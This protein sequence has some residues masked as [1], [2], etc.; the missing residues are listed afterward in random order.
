MNSEV[1]VTAILLDQI[2]QYEPFSHLLRQLKPEHFGEPKYANIWKAAAKL[3]DP[4]QRGLIDLINLL[5]D[6]EGSILMGELVALADGA[7]PVP[8]F[9]VEADKVRQACVLRQL[10][11]IAQ[12]LSKA[13]EQGN[14]N[15]I[16][17][18]ITRL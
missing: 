16:P 2:K 15:D 14:P 9:V 5:E 8:Q 17:Q 13:H 18:I 12:D 1:L 10:P 4:P 6:E 3:P 11:V 7:L